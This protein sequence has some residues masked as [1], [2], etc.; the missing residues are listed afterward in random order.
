MEG[1]RGRT[2][3]AGEERVE[4][5]LEAGRLLQ[6]EVEPIG[7]GVGGTIERGRP[8]RVREQ[9]GPHGA[10]LAAVAEAEV[11]DGTIMPW[12]EKP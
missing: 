6:C 2:A 10:E 7:R 5:L 1:A 9:G 8:H 4:G 11:A 12:R 3:T